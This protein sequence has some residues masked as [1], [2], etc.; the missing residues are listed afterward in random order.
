M[1]LRK[2]DLHDMVDTVISIDEFQPKAG[3]TEE[4]IVVAFTCLTEDA[5]NDLNIYIQRGVIDYVD[6]EVS[7][8]SDTRGRFYVFV[9]FERNE[10][11]QNSFTDLV[12]DI[13]N[14]TGRQDW[15]IK[16]YLSDTE[17]SFDDPDLFD[18]IVTD[19]DSYADKK[20]F[21]DKIKS[22]KDITES[23]IMFLGDTCIKTFE[24]S[25]DKILLDGSLLGTVVDFGIGQ[26]VLERQDLT[27]AAISFESSI[28]TAKLVYMLGEGWEVTSMGNTH[29]ITNN[30]SDD[31]I[32]LKNLELVY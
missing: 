8:F 15:V 30:M 10:K 11:F 1:T 27:E 13:E 22:H 20:E 2:N 6:V 24:H 26:H 21:E 4:I 16:P 14:L 3:D 12:D 28:E 25:G 5:A 19:A 23:V 31:A 18:W 32:V 9:E 29:V 17:V 7:P